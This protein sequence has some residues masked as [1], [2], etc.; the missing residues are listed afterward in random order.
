MQKS[1]E[2]ARED[3]HSRHDSS[4][5]EAFIAVSM[6]GLDFPIDYDSL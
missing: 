6:R 3:L 1:L 5:K 2:E 4:L